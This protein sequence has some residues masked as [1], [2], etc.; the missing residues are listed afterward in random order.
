[1]AGDVKLTLVFKSGAV[2]ELQAEP[3]KIGLIQSEYQ[4]HPDAKKPSSLQYKSGGR[5]DVIFDD[6][7]GMITNPG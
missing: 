2:V 5:M 1:M 6:L 3:G 4:S 7:S